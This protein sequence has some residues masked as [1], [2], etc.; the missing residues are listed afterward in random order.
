MLSALLDWEHLLVGCLMPYGKTDS[1]VPRKSN[2]HQSHTLKQH[3]CCSSR[4]PVPGS[5]KP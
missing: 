5:C 2:A 3:I 1:E 4:S